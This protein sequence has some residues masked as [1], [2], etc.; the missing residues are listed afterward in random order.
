MR[1]ELQ[2]VLGRIHYGGGGG[3]IYQSCELQLVLGRIHFL[4]DNG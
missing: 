3:V 4:S 2:L 1:C